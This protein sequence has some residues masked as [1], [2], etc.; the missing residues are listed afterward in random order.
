MNWFEEMGV[1]PSESW[2]WYVLRCADGSL[3]CGI[4]TDLARRLDQHNSGRGS[5]YV[6]S[7]RP[8][9]VVLR[10]EVG[11]RS[12]A[13]KREVAFKRLGKRQKEAVVLAAGEGRSRT[14]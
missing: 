9:T 8:A 5:K 3:Y 14:P 10:E 13:S 6:W 1:T 7:R 4:T 2:I 12:T 11:E